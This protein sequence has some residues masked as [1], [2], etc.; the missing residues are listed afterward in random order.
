MVRRYVGFTE[1]ELEI[2]ADGSCS[3][4]VVD[5]T[6]LP[7]TIEAWWREHDG[8]WLATARGRTR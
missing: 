4:H 5:A 8:H 7:V 1:V 6:R 3:V 2:A